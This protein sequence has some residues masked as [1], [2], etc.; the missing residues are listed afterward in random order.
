[1]KK[2]IV[3]LIILSVCPFAFADDGVFP[4]TSFSDYITVEYQHDE[5]VSAPQDQYKGWATVTVTNNMTEN[6]GDFHFNISNY[7]SQPSVYFVSDAPYAPNVNL[8]DYDVTF[9]NDNAY[10]PETVNFFFY[11]DP[12]IPGQS[13]TFNVYTDNT[14]DQNQWFCIS[15]CPT[16]VPEPATIALL[17]LGGLLLRKRK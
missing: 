13:V 11:D 7:A 12:V 6:W 16:P 9:T 17:G 8:A 4:N 1:M 3:S 14:T 2:F 15:M 5:P 10:G